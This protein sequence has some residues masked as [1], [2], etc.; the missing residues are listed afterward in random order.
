MPAISTSWKESFPRRAVPTLQVIATTG[1]ESTRGGNPGYQVGCTWAGSCQT[2]A[3]L[4]CRTGV[5]V[6]RVGS[7]CSWGKYMFNFITVSVKGV[8]NVQNSSAW[9]S[10]N[11]IHTLL[12]Q[13]FYDDLR[14]CKLQFHFLLVYYTVIPTFA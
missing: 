5:T 3:D 9:I 13:T 10:E 14:S 11:G 8:I 4:S 1:T 6:C 2:H 12:Q 7:P